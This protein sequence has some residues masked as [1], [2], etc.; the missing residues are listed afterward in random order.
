MAGEEVH[1]QA[2]LGAAV[3]QRAQREGHHPRVGGLLGLVVLL[4]RLPGVEVDA[5]AEHPPEVLVPPHHALGE[6]GGAARV[7]DVEVVGAALAEVALGALA[8]QR[9]GP[10]HA[11]VRRHVGL[12]V[13]LERVGHDH[14]DPE[15]LVLGH[16]GRDQRGVGALVDH[17]DHV[18][19]VEEVVELAL[20]VPV[21]H[22]DGD[23]P[24]L[25]HRQHGD[26]VLDAVLGVDR[27]VV[28]RA[29][30]LGL[31]VVR[32]PVGVGLQIGVR[33]DPFSDLQGGVV[34]CGVDGVFEEISDVVSHGPRLEHVLVFG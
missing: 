21:V 29:D 24:D 12:V 8:G 3:H 9:V 23:R 19:V 1:E 18:G 13:G 20:D 34:G 5:A 6:A 28:S 4:E 2:G 33:H 32:Q 11:A 26:D 10:E 22:V 16:A 14:R 15:L 7:D 30:S 27:D 25:D 17:G 31:Q